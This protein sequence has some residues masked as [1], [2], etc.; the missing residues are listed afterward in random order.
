MASL[1]DSAE[2]IEKSA[3]GGTLGSVSWSGG[4]L[5][6]ECEEQCGSEG[7]PRAVVMG[8][9][10]AAYGDAGYGIFH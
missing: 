7:V 4:V 9:A 5:A 2:P 8:L 1:G 10:P 6:T 3:E